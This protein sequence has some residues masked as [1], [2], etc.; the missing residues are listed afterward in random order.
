MNTRNEEGPFV[1]ESQT[2]GGCKLLCL[3]AMTHEV[4]YIWERTERNIT[5]ILD[6]EICLHAPNAGGPTRDDDSSGD[7]ERFEGV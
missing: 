5:H 7:A 2:H 1:A 3:S 4:R 6:T